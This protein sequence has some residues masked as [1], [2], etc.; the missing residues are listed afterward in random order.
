MGNVHSTY[1]S[2]ATRWTENQPNPDRCSGDTILWAR[3]LERL[4]N[5]YSSFPGQSL[6]EYLT[7][8]FQMVNF[9]QYVLGR[10][11]PCLPNYVETWHSRGENCS[12]DV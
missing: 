3:I 9:L 12:H 2:G 6:A 4:T 1:H 11:L 5:S 8:T 7:F 10:R